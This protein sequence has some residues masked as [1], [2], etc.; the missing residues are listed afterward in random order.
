MD[1]GD[2][3]QCAPRACGPGDPYETNLKNDTVPFVLY[4][5]RRVPLPLHDK[6][7][8]ELEKMEALGVISKADKATLWRGGMV[9][10]LKKS[11]DIR[12]CVD[13]NH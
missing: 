8:S 12:I 7:K 1:P 9:V 13:L 5:P 10:L 4:T 3:P 2:I 6:V 11:G